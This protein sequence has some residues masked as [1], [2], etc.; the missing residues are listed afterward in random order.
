MGADDY[1]TKPFSNKVLLQRIK[2]LLRRVEG[3]AETTDTVE[4]LGICID[5]VRHQVSVGKEKIELTPTEF[6]L[7]ECMLRQPGELFRAIS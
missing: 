3:G 7:L 6:R 1:V 5:R 2:A 4:H